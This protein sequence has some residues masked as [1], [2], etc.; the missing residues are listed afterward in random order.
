M[1][2]NAA[3]S[4]VTTGP[5]PA[6]TVPEAFLRICEV[7]QRLDLLRHTVDGWSAWPLIRFE[8]A[9]LLTATPFPHSRGMSRGQRALLALAD[10]P[11]LI[12]IKNARLLVKTYS[13]GLLEKSGDRYEDIWFD[14]VI[15]A[16]GSTF[17]IE[18]V[19]N[20]KFAVRSRRA[21]L[22]RNLSSSAL[23]IGASILARRRASP[24]IR[25]VAGELGSASRE[26]LGL[27]SVDEA[28][29]AARLRY[30][31]AMKR[32]Y[33]ALL[34]RVRPKFVLV[35]DP[36]EHSLVAA[37][38][39]NGSVVLELQHGINDRSHASYSWTAYAVPYRQ[40]M[41]VPD[42]L[43]LYGEYWRRELDRYSFW[44][45]S[46]RVVGSPRMDG[47]RDVKVIRPADKCTALF[48]TQGLDVRRVTEFL[49]AFLQNLRG[50]L[51]LELVIKLHPIFD[52]DKS[53]YLDALSS[54]RDQVEVLAGDEGASTFELLGRANLHM[55]IASASHYDA[56]GLG[57]PTVILPFLTH[58]IVLPL[59]RAGHAHFVRTPQELCDLVL[60][61]RE[62]RVPENVSEYYFKSGALSNI[63]REL[64]PPASGESSRVPRSQP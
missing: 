30:F 2:E 43:L 54:F 20:P 42:R 38:K 32:V 55:S 15:V 24:E 26:E 60:G 40:I 50:R 36:G 56:I 53:I 61:W 59:H 57:V 8:I 19:N 1:T 44:G 35:A 16:A 7:E 48:T 29:I 63:V 39:E 17:K 46:L 18:M 23:E 51:S 21:L 49:R 52:T 28:W 11:R 4:P 3:V 12:R 62:L 34:R 33:A 58:E 41:P 25:S 64:E 14:N 9:K 6:P 22:R 31:S 13:S 47:Y 45:D 37:A 10:L 27:E 5:I